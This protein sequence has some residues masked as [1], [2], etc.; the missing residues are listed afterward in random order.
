MRYLFLKENSDV[1]SLFELEVVTFHFESYFEFTLDF[2]RFHARIRR[3]GGILS[4]MGENSGVGWVLLEFRVR[5]GNSGV[6]IN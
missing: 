6:R 4:K 2:D 5:Q 1:R 3:I